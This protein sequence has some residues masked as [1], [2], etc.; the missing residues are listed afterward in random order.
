MKGH[1]Y[2][3]SSLWIPVLEK[4]CLLFFIVHT[5]IQH[6]LVLYTVGIK[7]LKDPLGTEYLH[8]QYLVSSHLCIVALAECMTSST[9]SLLTQDP[10][11]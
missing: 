1:V 11:K 9:L 8:L 6:P 3:M 4:T 10:Q 2:Q 5:F 7:R